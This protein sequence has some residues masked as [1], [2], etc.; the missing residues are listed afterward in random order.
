VQKL[1]QREREVRRAERL[2]AVGQLAAGVAHEIRNPLTSIKLLIQTSRR[3]PAAGGLSE[4]DLDLIEQEIQ[5]LEQAVQTFLNYARPPKLERSPCDLTLLVRRTFGLVRGR[6]ESQHVTLQFKEPE[7]PLVIDADRG[8]LQQVLVN[9]ALNALDAMPQGGTLDVRVVRKSENEVELT[10]TDSGTGIAPDVLNQLFEPFVTAK[11]TGLGL[12]LVVSRRIV[13]DHGG[14][15]TGAN[16]KE[17][18]ACFV[19]RLPV[20]G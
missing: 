12:G 9:L 20:K 2:A 19:I 8:Q 4:E 15:I 1:Q 18:G 3:D 5:R 16:R 7:H 11:E 17:G 14:T 6:A 10:V 13:E